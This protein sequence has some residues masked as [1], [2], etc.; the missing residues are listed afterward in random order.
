M[1]STSSSSS[2]HQC[3]TDPRLLE[4]LALSGAFPDIA[5]QRQAQAPPPSKK[6]MADAR[7]K[8]PKKKKLN[9]LSF[10]LHAPSTTIRQALF[11][12]GPGSYPSPTMALQQPPQFD[13]RHHQH[14]FQ[15]Q[16][17]DEEG[18]TEMGNRRRETG[19]NTSFPAE[20]TKGNLK[21]D[22]QQTLAY[23]EQLNR[24]QSQTDALT[25]GGGNLG[26]GRPGDSITH[27][28]AHGGPSNDC[29]VQSIEELVLLKEVTMREG[30]L[31]KLT[32]LVK[33]ATQDQDFG[34]ERGNELL[35]LL[36]Q[37]RDASVQVVQAVAHWHVSLRPGPC[38]FCYDGK[39]Y[40]LKMVSDLNFLAKTKSLGQILGVNPAR[41]KQNPFMTPAPIPERDFHTIQALSWSHTQRQF[42]SDPVERVADAE[43]YLV[44]CLI[45]L[46]DPSIGAAH[47]GSTPPTALAASNYTEKGS[48]TWQKR[49]EKQLQM[50][51]MP[52]EAP[53]GQTHLMDSSP[54]M[55]RKGYL[56]SLALSPPKTL[57]D[58]LDT[59]HS[60]S[61][62]TIERRVLSFMHLR[63]H[64]HGIEF[65]T[66]SKDLEA[67][68][69][70]E[71]PPHHMVTLVAASILIL[72]SPSDRIP[73][74]LSW[75]SCRK[76]LLSG[77]KLVDRME[78][79]EV[80]S[81]PSFKLK[82]L[83]PFL[84]NDHFQ[85]KF[86]SEFS[87]AAG[88][89]CAWVFASLAKAQNQEMVIATSRSD[90]DR[91]DILGEL[92]IENGFEEV[93]AKLQ[94]SALE[95][96]P[97]P[98]RKSKSAKRVT[99]G[100]AEVLFINENQPVSPSS[101]PVSRGET[102]SLQQTKKKSSVLLRTSPWN[103][104]SVTYFVSFFLEQA[105]TA[106]SIKLYEPMS[107]VESQIFVTEDDLEEDFGAS[108]FEYFQSR[109]YRP[110]CDLIL[111]RLDDMM[112]GSGELSG[113]RQETGS[114]SQRQ[115]MDDAN[116]PEDDTSPRDLSHQALTTAAAIDLLEL[117]E[118]YEE[119]DN[120]NEPSDP[121][122]EAG[123][124]EEEEEGGPET[125]SSVVRIQCAAR[126]RLARGKVRKVRFEKEKKREFAR[127]ES[128]V[129]IQSLAR[130][131]FAKKEVTRR[132]LK[133]RRP[134]GIPSQAMMFQETKVGE[135]RSLAPIPGEEQE[136]AENGEEEPANFGT[137]PEDLDQEAMAP[138]AGHFG[139]AEDATGRATTS[140]AGDEEKR[141]AERPETVMSYASDQF[142]DDFEDE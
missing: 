32:N 137:T 60:S 134:T 4:D 65:A 11:P 31:R 34:V 99:I 110:L 37:L 28:H 141:G 95:E 44:W 17:D 89:L 82:A 41:M 2:Y 13:S 72:L 101:R 100:N 1:Y 47:F 127:R 27:A 22:F 30:L 80:G 122:E 35:H 119:D 140:A 45:H 114:V 88:A 125:D 67:L 83:V 14:K 75:T 105:D 108:A 33:S 21:G 113:R 135:H 46:A 109:D 8:G 138:P 43:K 69:M 38:T 16:R 40:L 70:L 71:S 3:A 91:L 18:E 51:S 42:A 20:Y 86:L 81:V 103:F 10:P 129:R 92:E 126:Q 142:E 39:N 9:T 98:L 107:S 93:Q 19:W 131:N 116:E 61:Q 90:E 77:A 85:P 123:E 111:G 15:Q 54:M 52:L 121:I 48:T 128:A 64:W 76:M 62:P 68:G 115:S 25:G 117:D 139:D 104:N 118:G 53:S 63:A 102:P 132:R 106:L 29:D 87:S 59:V 7:K 97:A 24:L 124:A 5:W 73:K 57:T 96:Q 130:Q 94:S 23:Q 133:H 58:L 78:H 79:F 112:T 120:G 49:A 55:K 84:Q 36:L 26:F 136:I 74:D 6:Q 66:S 56:P 50:L 12:T